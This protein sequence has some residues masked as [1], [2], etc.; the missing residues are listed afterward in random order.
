MVSRSDPCEHLSAECD[1]LGILDAELRCLGWADVLS[2]SL[3]QAFQ[4]D[5]NCVLPFLLE[6]KSGIE[7]AQQFYPGC[8]LN[9]FVSINT[10]CTSIIKALADDVIQTHYHLPFLT[11]GL[12]CGKDKQR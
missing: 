2:D 12:L 5:S 3:V 4:N 8:Y 1:I 6:V 10:T 11:G 9:Y 7:N